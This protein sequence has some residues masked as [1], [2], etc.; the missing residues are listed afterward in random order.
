MRGSLNDSKTLRIKS[1]RRRSACFWAALDVGRTFYSRL[2]AGSPSGWKM[3]RSSGNEPE[4]ADHYFLNSIF[5]N[6]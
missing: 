6:R 4:R 3:V 1:S 5:A 2:N